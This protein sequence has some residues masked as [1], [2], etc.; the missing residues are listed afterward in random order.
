MVIAVDCK[1]MLRH[2]RFDS[3]RSHEGCS[4]IGNVFDLGSN[5]CGF[6]SHH[7]EGFWEVF[8]KAYRGGIV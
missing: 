2:C 6:D 7:P 8:L 3:Y 5:D 4:I 1:S